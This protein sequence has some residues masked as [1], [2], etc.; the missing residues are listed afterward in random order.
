[1]KIPRTSSI[2]SHFTNFTPIHLPFENWVQNTVPPNRTFW[3]DV[4]KKISKVIRVWNLEFVR[5]SRIF[6]LFHLWLK[7]IDRLNVPSNRTFWPDVEQPSTSPDSI[8][9]HGSELHG[10]R[11]KSKLLQEFT[12][13]P[14]YLVIYFR[15]TESKLTPCSHKRFDL[16]CADA[17]KSLRRLL[18][19]WMKINPK[20][21][22]TNFSSDI[23]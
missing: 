23:H 6:N 2:R 11:Q 20:V 16:I 19:F 17:S 5:I 1:M 4:S 15:T 22:S 3:Q 12:S 8:W 14:D 7:D 9:T 13:K 10:I 18:I 21:L